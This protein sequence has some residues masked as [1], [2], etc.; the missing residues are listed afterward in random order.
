M[1]IAIVTTGRFHVFD[2]A[3]E[4]AALGHDV[5]FYSY[6][7]RRRAEQFGLPRQCHRALLSWVLPLIA[8]QRKGPR[9]WGKCL[10]DLLQ[11]VVD[12]LAAFMSS[13]DVL[14]MRP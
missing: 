6:V 8:A 5:A 3:R 7:P 4:M 10:D 2:L 14:E 11:R 9:A 1:R 12:G 13:E